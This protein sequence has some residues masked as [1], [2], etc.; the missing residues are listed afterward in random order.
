MKIVILFLLFVVEISGQMNF[1]QFNKIGFGDLFRLRKIS[2]TAI[3]P[4]ELQTHYTQLLELGLTHVATYASDTVLNAY[5]NLKIIDRNFERDI[6]AQNSNNAAF[7][8]SFAFGNKKLVPY[9]LG[10]DALT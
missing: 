5:P 8:Y 2:D 3:Q 4:N 1:S 10:G 7:R 6:Y 9:E